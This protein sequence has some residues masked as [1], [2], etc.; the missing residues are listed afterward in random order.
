MRSNKLILLTKKGCCLCEALEERLREIPL[1]QI[2]P[3][4]ELDILDIDSE[5]VS[6][7]QAESYSL[8]VPVLFCELQE[9]LRRYKLPRASPRLSQDGLLNWLKKVIQRSIETN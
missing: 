8:E 4:F 5:E 6:V 7:E 9:P 1:D 2:K 3:S